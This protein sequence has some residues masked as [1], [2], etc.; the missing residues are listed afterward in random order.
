VESMLTVGPRQD[1]THLLAGDDSNRS[2]PDCSDTDFRSLQILQDADR[3]RDLQFQRAYGGVHLGVIVVRA[4][5]KVQPKRV[6]AGEEQRFQHFGRSGRRTD[7][8]NDFGP[9]IAAHCSLGL[10]AAS[11]D[12]NGSD[13]VDIG[14]GR[15]GTNEVADPGKEAV[16]V[17]CDQMLASIQ[18]LGAR[19]GKRIWCDDRACSVLGSVDSVAVACERKD[20]RLSSHRYRKAE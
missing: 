16:A 7:C 3:T 14:A 13:V 5:T 9:A 20:V 19:A 6:N 4:M 2:I 10:S 17:M 15:P 11:G 12:Q 1:K 8:S 18:I